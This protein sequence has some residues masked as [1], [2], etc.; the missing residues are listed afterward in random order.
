M[1][2]TGMMEWWKIG[3]TERAMSGLKGGSKNEKESD[4]F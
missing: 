2:S 4:S 3:I 1:V